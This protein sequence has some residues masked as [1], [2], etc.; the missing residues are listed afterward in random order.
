MKD[1]DGTMNTLS[2]VSKAYF[3]LS[4]E[5]RTLPY[6]ELIA[7]SEAERKYLKIHAKLDQVVIGECD[8]GFFEVLRRRAALVRYA[9]VMLG[10]VE[11]SEGVEGLRRLLKE[12]DTLRNLPFSHV[13]FKRVKRYG[14]NIKYADVINVIRETLRG[15]PRSLNAPLIDVIV[16]EGVMIVGY[17]LFARRMREFDAR[18]PQRRPV[19]LPGTLTPL[20]SRIFVN[21]SRVGP[22]GLFYD[23]FCGV[24][25]FLLEACVMGLKYVGSDI[26]VRHVTG[27]VENLM[28]YGCVPQVFVAD[29]CDMPVRKVS[30]I[31]T[32]P[33]YGRLTQ[34][35]CSG[36]LRELME[37]FLSKAAE[38]LI[39]GGYLA[40]AQRKDVDVEGVIDDVGLKIVE[41]HLNWVHG[42]LTRDIF[43]VRKP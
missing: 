41:R 38:T 8:E 12:H 15:V 30:S 37:C 20:W 26:S 25:G 27:A 24:G 28:Y 43:V 10:A 5:H 32:D 34:V 13:A 36:G 14:H 6:S 3:F 39:S 21:L 40:F 33:P 29:A 7:L 16:S 19:Y 35:Q 1:R 17:R 2:R 42:A 23:P 22:E 4:G 11:T 9:G 18:A 31:G